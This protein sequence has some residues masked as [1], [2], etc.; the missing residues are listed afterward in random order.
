MERFERG[1]RVLVRRCDHM[2]QPVFLGGAPGTVYKP[3]RNDDGA[4]IELDARS[5][6][7]NAHPFPEDDPGDRGRHVLAFPGDCDLEPATA[8]GGR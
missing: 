5:P 8:E 6:T 3:R 1:Q 2:G 4:W 7:L